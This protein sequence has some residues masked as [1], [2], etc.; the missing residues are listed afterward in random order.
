M[1]SL[2]DAHSATSGG[3]AAVT[4][5]SDLGDFFDQLDLNDDDFADVEIDDDDLEIQESVRWLALARV[6]TNK[7]FSPSAFYKDMRAAWNPTQRVGFRPVGLIVLS[8]KHPV[9]ETGN[10]LCCKV[11]KLP[12]PYCKQNIVEKL[13]KEA[14]EIM[15]MWLDGN[16]RDVPSKPRT[17][18]RTNK[19]TGNEPKKAEN[20][21]VDGTVREQEPVDER[22]PIS[23]EAR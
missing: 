8:S 12:N 6:H 14:R 3:G 18:T 9:W 20:P 15:E 4:A 21:K 2:S 16:T 7:N 19:A 13:L 5:K 17:H 22:S 11:H 23:L 10:A 1:A